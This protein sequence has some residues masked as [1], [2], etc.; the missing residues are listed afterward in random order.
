[1]PSP[2]VHWPHDIEWCSDKAIIQHE[3]NSRQFYERLQR[4]ELRATIFKSKHRSPA[5]EPECTL[6]QI[7]IYWDQNNNPVAMVH[8]YLRPD[9]TI[10]GSG[11]PDPKRIVVGDKVIALRAKSSRRARQRKSQPLS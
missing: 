9:N 7:L 6:S 3:F 8:Q 10:G 11:K 5:T 1:M 4:N 2:Y